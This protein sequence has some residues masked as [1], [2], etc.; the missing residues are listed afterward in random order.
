MA[1]PDD[2]IAELK[3]AFPGVSQGDEGGTTYFLLPQV[4]LPAGWTPALIDLLL[5]PTA[6]DGYPSRL[7]FAERPSGS[8]S[9]NWNAVRFRILERNWDAFSWNLNRT[10]LRLAQMVAAFLRALQ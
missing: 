8:K 7:F 5:C 9:F 2:Q 1:F 6:R 3:A 10:D 4:A